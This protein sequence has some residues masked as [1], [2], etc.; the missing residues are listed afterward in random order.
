[1]KRR[2]GAPAD[3]FE[4]E[5]AGLDWLREGP[6]YVPRVIEIGREHI[7]MERIEDSARAADFDAQLGRG[8]AQ[9]HDLGAPAF[10]G[11]RDNY[12]VDI[13][14]DNRDCADWP[15]FYVEQR[16]RPLGRRAGLRIDSRLDRLLERRDRFG[17]PESPARLHGDLWWGNVM[18]NVGAPALIDP[19]AYGGHREVDLA[20]LALFG[21]LPATVIAAYEEI[22]PLAADWRDRRPLYQLYPLAVHAALFGGGYAAQVMSILDVVCA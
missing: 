20:M 1:M 4:A 5:A 9:L 18:C 6:L 21:P 13:P 12:I 19:A 3:L 22:H 17:P 2:A 15:M 14:Q 10:G 8:L 16:L 11:H 7:A